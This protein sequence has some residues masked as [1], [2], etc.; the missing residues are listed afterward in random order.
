MSEIYGRYKNVRNNTWQI[1]IDYKIS[2]LPVKISL[3]AINAGIKII[4]DSLVHELR[5][6]EVGKS[7]LN[8]NQ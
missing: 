7:I 1:L 4:K 6:N 3:I 2:S 5:D 8:N